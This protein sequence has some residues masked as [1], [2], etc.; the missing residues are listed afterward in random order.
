MGLSVGKVGVIASLHS[1]HPCT[2]NGEQSSPK[3]RGSIVS[4]CSRAGIQISGTL[5]VRQLHWEAS[6]EGTHTHAEHL[7]FLSVF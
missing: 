7:L 3:W 4:L 5:I 2:V 1:G 6:D